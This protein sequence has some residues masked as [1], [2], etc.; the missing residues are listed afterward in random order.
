MHQ[1]RMRFFAAAAAIISC[2]PSWAN[3]HATSRNQQTDGVSQANGGADEGSIST[4]KEIVV[5]AEK[6]RENIQTVPVAVSAFSGTALK[7]AHITN[8]QQL[9]T[10][11]SSLNVTDTSSG[12]QPFIRGIGTNTSGIGI[13]PA[14]ATYVDGIYYPSPAGSIFSYN[15]I[16]RIEILKGPQGTLFGRN[17][18]GGVI[19]IITQNPTK[20]PA[21]RADVGYANY[22]TTS[23][24]LYV[25][26]GLSKDLSGN[27]A[28]SY[29]HQGDGWGKNVING[30]DVYLNNDIGARTKLLLTPSSRTRIMLIADYEKTR[31]DQGAADAVVPGATTNLGYGHPGGFYD[32]NSNISPYNYQKQWGVALK[33][34]Q[35]LSWADFKS[36]SAWRSENASAFL[37]LDGTPVPFVQYKFGE[38]ERTITQEFNLESTRSSKINWIVGFYYFNDISRYSPLVQQGSA[39]GLG[40]SGGLVVYARQDT[41]SYAGY[42]QATLPLV[43]QSTHLT[44]GLRYT[45]D[46][47]SETADRFLLG[48]NAPAS[49]RFPADFPFN[50][51]QPKLNVRLSLDHEFTRNV[52]TYA[53]YTTGFKSGSYSLTTP[54]QLPTKPENLSSYEVGIKSELFNHTVRANAAAF[55]YRFQDLQVSQFVGTSAVLTNAA[56][57]EYK[58]ID[59]DFTI[60]PTSSL[61]F[62]GGITYVDAHYLK[63]VGAQFVSPLPTGG[64]S[65]A[66]PGDARGNQVLFVDPLEVTGTL[67]YRTEHAFGALTAR[68]TVDHH[69]SYFFDP[70]NITDQPAYTTLNANL[71]LVLPSGHVSISLWGE[72]LSNVHY[73]AARNKQAGV[74]DLFVAAPPRTF[75]VRL[76]YEM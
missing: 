58:G 35:N 55:Y 16:E 53:S 48:S 17:A 4:L 26:D 60:A 31:N 41:K 2:Y 19:N 13:E 61:S 49:Y 74:G 25:S 46:E 66:K 8:V 21:L 69:S 12:F 10:L 67:Q 9:V 38:K 44:A 73:F 15:D 29:S 43:T 54:T 14:V 36:I 24:N 32:I 3:A 47:K 22:N 7:A 20:T 56:D 1:L 75:G 27:L 50:V 37:E 40:P 68:F 65:G 42:A 59:A 23:A 30:K 63:Y 71:T 76:G 6:R 51:R 57:A 33:L 39:Y 11:A 34:D 45:L 62:I 64:F 72:N 70:Q 5:T 52:M 28:V 18:A